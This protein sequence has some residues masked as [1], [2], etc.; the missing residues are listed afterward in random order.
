M[1]ILIPFR[2]G[3]RLKDRA[4]YQLLRGV[5]LTRLRCRVH[6]PDPVFPGI[7]LFVSS[8][9]GALTIA[10]EFSIAADRLRVKITFANEQL[11]FVGKTQF[12][13]HTLAEGPHVRTHGTLIVSEFISLSTRG[14]N[15]RTTWLPSFTWPGEAIFR[16]ILAALGIVQLR[17]S[18]DV[19]DAGLRRFRMV[20]GV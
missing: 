3:S 4:G 14:L 13:V 8:G 15:V 16:M 1:R 11:R 10:Y 18:L 9:H 19:A 7:V 17:R 20:P 5:F 2:H 12:L 6:F